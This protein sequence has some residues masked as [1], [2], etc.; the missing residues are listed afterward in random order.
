MRTEKAKHNKSVSHSKATHDK[1]IK[2][3]IKTEYI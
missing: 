1:S 3:I 2:E